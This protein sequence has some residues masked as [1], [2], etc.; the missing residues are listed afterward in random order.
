MPATPL[1]KRIG[2]GVKLGVD[3]TGASTFT[4][5]G[6]I[7]EAISGPEAKAE[8][9]D[10]SLLGDIYKTFAKSAIDSGEVTFEVAYDPLETV[11]QTLATLF[12]QGT[13]TPNWQIQYPPDNTTETFLGHVVGLGREVKKAGM[14][15]KKVTIKVSGDP[16]FKH[17]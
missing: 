2:L 17:S 6:C 5:I 13:P 3:P 7:V 11:N 14:I 10:T 15:L 16:G 4:D 1:T 9:V 12:T 8:T